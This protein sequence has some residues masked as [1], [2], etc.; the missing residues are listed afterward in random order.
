MSAQD[1]TIR[2]DPQAPPA[3][4]STTKRIFIG[5][6]GL[7]AGW[8]LLIFMAIVMAIYP[9][10]RMIIKRFFPAALDPAQLTPMRIIAPDL[11]F[12]FILAA[13]AWIMSKIEG[14]RLGQYGLPR[15]QA[16]RKH[17]WEGL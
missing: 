13:A 5:P 15:S 9:V 14:R 1:T 3:A 7:R 6:N 12:C 16:L 11:L 2:H 10:A 8:R 4:D 17:F